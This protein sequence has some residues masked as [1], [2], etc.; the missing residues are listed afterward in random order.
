VSVSAK[1]KKDMEAGSW[2]RRMFEDGIAMK[3]RY[4][5]ENVYDLS[6]GNPVMEPPDEFVRDIAERLSN[7]VVAHCSLSSNS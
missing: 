3:R 5:A 4:G 7:L 2:I 1:I 6:L